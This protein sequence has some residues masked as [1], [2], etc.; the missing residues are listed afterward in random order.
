MYKGYFEKKMYFCT[1]KHITTT[2][3]AMMGVTCQ[4]AVFFDAF[5]SKETQGESV[6]NYSLF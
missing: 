6:F 2:L 5:S 1:M 4:K 3:P